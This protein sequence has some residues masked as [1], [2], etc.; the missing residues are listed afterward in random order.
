MLNSAGR[1]TASENSS[2]LIPLADLT[3]RRTRVTRNIRMT[4][5]KV[6]SGGSK[7]PEASVLANLSAASPETDRNTDG[8][9]RSPHK[10]R[11]FY[12]KLEAV[13]GQVELAGMDQN[14]VVLLLRQV[15]ERDQIARSSLIAS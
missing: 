5:N 11:P 2:V 12:R 14:T 9:S 15:K 1:D 7:E 3:S 8:T 6:G 13:E 10:L 4:R